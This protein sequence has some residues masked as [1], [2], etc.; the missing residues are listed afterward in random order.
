MK[1]HLLF[2]LSF[3]LLFS[4]GPG[5]KQSTEVPVTSPQHIPLLIPEDQIIH[6]GIFS[7]DQNEYY[8][9]LSDKNFENFD[10]KYIKKVNQKWSVPQNAFIN[11]G[12]NDHGMSFSPDGK[13][14]YF[15]STR[16]VTQSGKSNTWHIWRSEKINNKW[17]VPMHID[18][19][20][21]HGK[22]ISHPTISTSGVLYFHVSNLDYSEMDIYFS[23][24]VNGVFLPAE[25]VPIPM[26]VNS[27]KCT[28]Y[29]SADNSYL[30]F[31]AIGDQLDL[32]ISFR[33]KNGDWTPALSLGDSINQ[34]GQGNPSVTSDGKFLYFTSGSETTEDWVVNK[35]DMESILK[36][37]YIQLSAQENIQSS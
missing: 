15:S 34:N 32:M 21:L 26:E 31:A 28:P 13:Y 11:S 19:P 23:K 3:I 29:I 17:S 2:T 12:F 36:S 4:C 24:Q 27:Y 25:K 20:N 22:L 7:P 16:P 1:Y 9:T 10:I 33:G 6:R 5:A 35:V 18:I 14:L 8:Y 30:I 37:L